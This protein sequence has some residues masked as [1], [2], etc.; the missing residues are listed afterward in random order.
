[1]AKVCL[2]FFLLYRIE[3]AAKKPDEESKKNWAC[4]PHTWSTVVPGFTNTGWPSTNTSIWLLAAVVV[5][6]PKRHGKR[7]QKLSVTAR[8]KPSDPMLLIL[9]L[10]RIDTT[11]VLWTAE[12]RIPE[13]QM[14]HTCPSISQ[15]RVQ[16][17]YHHRH[18]HKLETLT[19][20]FGGLGHPS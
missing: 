8:C 17:F 5:V 3:H 19:T 16:E 13:L 6:R 18:I 7:K 11:P 9:R 20:H 1:M 12:H 4:R 10:Y 2:G 14:M 15:L